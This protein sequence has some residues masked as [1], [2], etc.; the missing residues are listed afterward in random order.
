M[1]PG[2]S[3]VSAPTSWCSPGCHHTPRS[4]RRSASPRSG[5]A[6][7]STPCSARSHALSVEEMSWPS[8]GAR[9]SYPDWMVERFRAELGDDAVPALERMNEPPPVTTR[10]DGYVQDESSQWVAA[11]VG[12]HRGSGSSTCARRP[13]ARPR[14]WRATEPG[15]RRRP[16]RRPRSVGRRERRRL[17]LRLPVVAADGTLPPFRP[18]SF[19]AVLLDAPCS[20]LGALRRRADARWRIRPDDIGELARLQARLLTASAD[21]S[22]RAAASSTACARSPPR[23]RSTT[24]PRRLRDRPDA[25]GPWG[26]GGRSSRAGGCFPTTPTPTPWC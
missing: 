3:C 20:G 26:S 13:A 18:G 14:R 4:A 8:D 12:Q 19:D 23:S 25:S 9:L 6:G 5:P 7:S 17:G 24:R 16:A 2:R 1:P 22:R 15:D 10:A 21:W 11:A